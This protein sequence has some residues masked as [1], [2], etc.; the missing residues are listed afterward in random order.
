[1]KIV[2]IVGARPQFIKAAV[3]SR[4]IQLHPHVT[5]ILV[6]T[7]QHYDANMSDVF[8]EEMEIPRPDYF[9]G[10]SGLSHG[11]MTGRMIE[12]VEKLLLELKPDYLVVFGDTNSTLAPAI[13]AKKIGIRT[14]HIEAGVRN[15]DEYMP[16]EINRYLVDRLSEI[17]FCC[18]SLGEDNLKKEGFGTPAINSEVYNYGDVMYD[19]ALFYEKK[20]AAVSGILDT[21]HL[22]NREYIICT[23]HR[24][25]NTND[26]AALTEIIGAL[27]VINETTPVVMPLHPRTRKK[28]A[29]FG[30]TAHFTCIDPVGYYDMIQLVKGAKYVITDSGGVVR[31][32]YFFKRPSLVLMESPFWPELVDGGY[33]VNVAPKKE[34]ML[35]SFA[36]LAD[37][38]KDYDSHIFG[39]G[40]A[41]EKIISCII[42]HHKRT[43]VKKSL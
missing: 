16:E 27:N 43:Q 15:Y 25:A 41:G 24:E 39:D 36:L 42:D 2:T 33:C 26:P 12:E 21:L 19:A 11:A 7:G 30:L 8:F 29:D 38:N 22:K 31:E 28:L 3:L 10:I 32:A 9:L 17:N 18:S 37:T 6:H 20:S 13:A 40:H 14:V 35:R 4:A 5:Q 23:T 34:D 1:M